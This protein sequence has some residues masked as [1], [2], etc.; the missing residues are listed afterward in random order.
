MG[1]EIIV[2][3]AILILSLFGLIGSMI[4]YVAH[5]KNNKSIELK[6][7]HILRVISL[8]LVGISFMGGAEIAFNG[9]SMTVLVCVMFIIFGIFINNRVNKII[10]DLR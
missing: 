9:N 5:E 3:G 4:G 10:D 8:A 7:A 1:I 6:A 2:L